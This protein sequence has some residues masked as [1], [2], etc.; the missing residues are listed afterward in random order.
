MTH[1]HT[2]ALAY[3]TLA[4]VNKFLLQRLIEKIK[5]KFLKKCGT[6]LSRTIFDL[7]HIRSPLLHHQFYELKLRQFHK[8]WIK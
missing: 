4:N 6:I 7:Y 3:V 2:I 8:K 5:R 1:I